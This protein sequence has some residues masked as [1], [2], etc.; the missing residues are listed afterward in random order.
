MKERKDLPTSDRQAEGLGKVRVVEKRVPVSVH[1]DGG[2]VGDKLH[3]SARSDGCEWGKRRD[4][5]DVAGVEQDGGGG[6]E[7]KGEE[8]IGR[9]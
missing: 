2:R 3:S 1:G 9:G 5:A 6:E 8:R 4:G 7:S